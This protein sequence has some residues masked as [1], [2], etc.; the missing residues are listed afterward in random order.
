MPHTPRRRRTILIVAEVFLALGAARINLAQTKPA[1]AAAAREDLFIFRDVGEERGL[2]PAV[3][4]IRGHAAA[5]GDADGD[6]FPDLFVGTF[7]EAGSKPSQLFRNTGG[8]F[9]VE[10]Q[11]SLQMDSCASGAVFVDLTNSGHLDLYINNN[12]HGAAGAKAAPAKLLRNDGV[13]K[14]TDVS[15]GS[16]ACPAGFQGRTVAA[17]DYDGDG[18]LD[19]VACDFYYSTKSTA[20]IALYR[21]LGNYRFEDVTERAGLPRGRAISGCAV[22]DFNGDGWP[23]LLLVGADG[24]NRIYLSDGRGRF[25]EAPGR[26]ETFAWKGL[27]AENSPA[28][29]CI[30]D[31]NRDGLPD[32]VIGHHFKQ[33]WQKPTPVRLYLNR[34]MKD[35]NSG[36]ED[37]TEAAGLEPLAMKAP[38]LEFQDFDNDGWPDLFVSIV[39]FKDGQPHPLIYKNLGLRDGVPQ[40][41]QSAWAVNDFPT[42]EDR[43]VKRTGDFFKKMV[44]DKK[45]MYMAAAPT[46]DFDCDGRMDI[47]MANWWI[48][49]RSLLL[50]NETPGGHWLQ[51]SVEGSGGVNRMGI[52]SRVRIF[53]S[54]KPH[55]SAALL[56]DREIAVG[57]GWCSGQEAVVHFGLGEVRAVDVEVSLPHGKGTL[58]RDNVKADQRLAIRR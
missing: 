29:V 45:I 58:A 18:L 5:W 21:N 48:E 13:G 38:C 56:G 25:A 11:K 20:G 41:R 16:G 52:G 28:G 6:G 49:S 19:L 47:F 14:F 54:G 53:T 40:F 7:H 35:G 4:A 55:D 32:V 37:V 42:V 50:K 24:D 23:D 26:R 44:D 34:G 27:T 12:A 36:F 39:K 2:F 30:A 57:Y 33:P 1:T 51:V 17:L 10:D 3:T 9:T 22:A 15:E 46:A 8:R 43:A 31:I